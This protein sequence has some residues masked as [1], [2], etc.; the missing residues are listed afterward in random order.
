V[1]FVQ[2]GNFG[3]ER[4][5]KIEFQKKV[6]EQFLLLKAEDEEAMRDTSSSS[7]SATALRHRRP[8][9]HVVDARQSI[10]EVHRQIQEIA[11]A[12]LA[13]VAAE[14][15]TPIGAEEAGETVSSS[16]KNSLCRMWTK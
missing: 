6:R 14:V 8:K 5:E 4:Y 11:S 16:I 13:E 2:R 12:T 7:S 15:A 3:D 9:W 10:E 1:N